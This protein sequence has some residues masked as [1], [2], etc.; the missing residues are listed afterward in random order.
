MA[1]PRIVVVG[2]GL[3]GLAAAYFTRKLLG[4]A[5]EVWVFEAADRWGGKVATWQTEEYYVEL[6]PDSLV[7]SKPAA[8]ELAAELGLGED[9][10]SPA[11]LPAFIY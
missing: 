7:V 8:L 2:G 10:I 1:G 9:F 6:G 4:P 11:P 3:S 5:A